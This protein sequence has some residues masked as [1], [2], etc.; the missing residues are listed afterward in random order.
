MCQQQSSNRKM[1]R[2][3][4]G[5]VAKETRTN[6][7]WESR[8]VFPIVKCNAA[9]DWDL[10]PVQSSK[11]CFW[12]EAANI[13]SRPPTTLFAVSSADFLRADATSGSYLHLHTQ[14]VLPCPQACAR[15]LE[16]S[17][18]RRASMW[19]MKYMA[20]GGR[21]ADDALTLFPASGIQDIR[22][23]L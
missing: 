3:P 2:A 7:F 17:A 9:C 12:C 20:S 23:T 22:R 16:L 11:I 10:V 1:T 5:R 6:D 4:H 8:R 13:F 19:K 21:H 15:G 18:A 14:S